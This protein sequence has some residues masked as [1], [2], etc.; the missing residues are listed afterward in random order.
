MTALRRLRPDGMA[1]RFALLLVAALLTA[2]LV[3]LALLGFERE[4]L[5][6]VARE[7]REV[8]R[9]VSLLPAIEAAAP[10]RRRDI[11]REAS[12]RFS[13]VSVGPAPL[14]RAGADAPR[15]RALTRDLAEALPGRDIRAAVLARPGPGERHHGEAVAVSIRLA[16]LAPGEE[17]WL[18][19]MSRGV[20]PRPSA[21]REE[22]FLIV[23]GISLAAVLGVGLAF[24][25][26]L[27]RPLAG[28]AEAARAAGRG[29]R[30]AR[31][32][33]TGPRELREAARAF[34]DMQARIARFDA[35]RMRLLAAVGH[36][37]R[38]PITSLRIRAELLDEAEAGP[39][40]RTLDEMTVMA[41]GLVAYARGAGDGEAA[42]ALDLSAMLVRLCEERGAV[43]E[44]GAEGVFV[45]A[46]PVA[47]GRAV[48]NLLDN[49]L[50]Y[51][52][53]ARLRLSREGGEAVVT[54]EDDGPG[55]PPERLDAVFEPFVRGEDS[56]SAQTGGAGLGLSIARSILAA[57]GGSVSLEN[58]TRGGLR[59]TVR[60]PL[61][62]K[63]GSAREAAR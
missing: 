61:A 38:T 50:R 11:A 63:A 51:G 28:L 10:E 1:A 4:R 32:P 47:L 60:L 3:A 21:F 48:G 45:T 8:E 44:A 16:G 19:L 53:A 29:D 5:D 12:T 43:F 41:D 39:M 24:T 58:R 46:R 26:R 52:G 30:T 14:V 33:E 42:R 35:E 18:N 2:H 7:A 31:V 6:R 9:I 13:R 57:H 25:R 20:R 17:Q 36:D 34:N 59:A 55:I 40:I 56:R 37:L 23:L 15:S 22:V 62:P 27:T 49:A 54:V